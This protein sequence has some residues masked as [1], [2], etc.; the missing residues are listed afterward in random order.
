[1]T[2]ILRVVAAVCV[3]RDGLAFLAVHSNSQEE[4]SFVPLETRASSNP[5]R[6]SLCPRVNE[7]IPRTS[8]IAYISCKAREDSHDNTAAS[9]SIH[10]SVRGL[11]SSYLPILLFE[12][13]PPIQK[14]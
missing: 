14:A 10:N 11:S 2:D 7:R 12:P 6:E 4:K 5:R 8:Y 3:T 9:Q 1:M 13:L